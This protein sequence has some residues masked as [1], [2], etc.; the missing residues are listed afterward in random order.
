[1]KNVKD[2]ERQYNNKNIRI[3]GEFFDRDDLNSKKGC[4]LDKQISWYLIDGENKICIEKASGY[5][6]FIIGLSLRIS[7]SYI[8]A[9]GINCNQLFIDEGF[10]SCDKEHLREIPKFINNLLGKYESIILMSHLDIIQECVDKTIE[11]KRQN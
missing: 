7:L 3:Y 9:S 6:R 5:Q 8:G 11:I 10:T 1:M 4:K 2:N